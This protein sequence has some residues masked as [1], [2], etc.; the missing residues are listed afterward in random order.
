MDAP[1]A[2]AGLRDHE[3]LTF[4]TQERLLGDAHVLVVDQRMK[5]FVE[6]LTVEADV[7]HDVDPGVVAG[8]RN[9]DM[10]W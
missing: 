2:Q 5:A 10:P 8:T 1:T 9:M 3:G 6:T 7:A 4:S